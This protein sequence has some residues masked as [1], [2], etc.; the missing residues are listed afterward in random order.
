MAEPT[1]TTTAV[2]WF[3]GAFL[4]LLGFGTKFVSD[5]F[6]DKRTLQHE[7]ETRDALRRDQLAERR[8]NFQRQTLLELQEAVQDLIRATGAAHVQDERAFKE[9]GRWQREKLGEEI[10]QQI[11]LANRSVLL[12]T[13]RVR[14]KALR[15]AINRFRSLSNQTESFTNLRSDASDSELRNASTAA[16]QN[17]TTLIEQIHERI[18]ELLRTLDEDESEL[19][20]RP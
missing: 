19:I 5:W 4:V 11:F 6:Q 1:T 8:A 10:N 18:G 15:D 9:T 2:S 17:A 14:D 16:M 7:R 13:V 20:R 3:S 12:L